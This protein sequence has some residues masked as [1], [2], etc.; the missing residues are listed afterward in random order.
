MLYNGFGE[1]NIQGI[2][3]KHI[4]LIHNVTNTDL[5]TAV[6]DR[7]TDALDVLFNTAAGRAHLVDRQGVPTGVVGRL[8]DLGLSSICNVLASIKVAKRLGL[9]GDDVV[10]TVATDGSVLYDAERE[11][12]LAAQWPGGFDAVAAAQVFGEHLAGASDDHVLQLSQDDRTRIFNLGYFTWVEQ[13]GVALA[14]FEA[15]RS[16]S[17]WQSLRDLLAAWDH[18]ILE[19]NARTGVA[20][21][22]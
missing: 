5:V 17:F 10:V 9:G 11:T 12:R 6:S 18:L 7:S 19:F 8:G 20:P 22:G 1:H 2:G 13:Q 15:R 14:D 3:D 4:P 16:Q 21:S